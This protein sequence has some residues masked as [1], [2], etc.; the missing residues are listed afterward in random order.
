MNKIQLKKIDQIKASL[1]SHIESIGQ[2]KIDELHRLEKPSF[3]T[4]EQDIL[5]DVSELIGILNTLQ[6][7]IDRIE[8]LTSI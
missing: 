8:N 7:A 2:M 1:E 5:D 3:R 6:N 4:V